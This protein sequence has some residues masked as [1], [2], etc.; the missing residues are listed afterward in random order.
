M[1]DTPE[2]RPKNRRDNIAV[3]AS[4]KL[5]KAALEKRKAELFYHW[6]EVG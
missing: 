1:N 2:G 3:I 6:K 5:A 4:D